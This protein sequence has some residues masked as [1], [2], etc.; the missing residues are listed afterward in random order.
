MSHSSS[1][2]APRRPYRRPALTVFGDMR[3]LT[4]TSLT[5]NMNDPANSSQT[6]T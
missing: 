6:M 4:L 3:E 1:S 2:N 5:Q